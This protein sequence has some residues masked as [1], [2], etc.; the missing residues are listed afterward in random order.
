M[1]ILYGNDAGI[2]EYEKLRTEY[3]DNYYIANQKDLFY[4]FDRRQFISQ[5]CK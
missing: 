1:T 4:D 5:Y 3:P 2:K